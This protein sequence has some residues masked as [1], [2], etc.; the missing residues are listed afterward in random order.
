[1]SSRTSFFNLARMSY[2]R[3]KVRSIDFTRF[4][5]SENAKNFDKLGEAEFYLMLFTKELSQI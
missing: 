1:M 4:S 5:P 2:L 3:A